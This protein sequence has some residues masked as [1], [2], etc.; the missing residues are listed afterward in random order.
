MMTNLFSSFDPSTNSMMSIN[1]MSTVIGM[2]IMPYMYWMLPSRMMLMWTNTSNK[3][4][5]ELNNI[6]NQK[7]KS[8]T[9]MFIS[10]FIMLLVNNFMGLFPYIF[11]ST[12]HMVMTFSLAMPLWLT[13]MFFGWI[14]KTKNMFAH[15]V[16]MSTPPILMPFMVMI[17]TISN[18]IRPG[19]LAVRLSANMIAGHLLMTLMGNTGTNLSMMMLYIML[20]MQML[21]IIL[22][23]AV[24]VIQAYVYTVLSTLYF[25]EIYVNKKL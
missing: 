17:E 20:M 15:L 16:P 6:I 18:M 1:W 13:Y 7:D 22:E 4:H 5:N 11:T 2:M 23:S 3:L 10:M 12:S 24:A 19:T 21:L 14:K 25:S 8:M 9:L